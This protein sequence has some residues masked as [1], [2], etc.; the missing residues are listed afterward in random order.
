MAITDRIPGSIAKGKG[1]STDEKGKR[2]KGTRRVEN[3]TNWGGRTW[4]TG[5]HQ[6]QEEEYKGDDEYQEIFGDQF[7]GVRYAGKEI[8][9]PSHPDWG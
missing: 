1:N 7:M 6:I 5:N 4:D 9:S 3:V 2:G 8:E